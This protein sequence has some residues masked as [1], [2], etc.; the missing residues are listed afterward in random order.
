MRG[1]SG[2]AASLGRAC[3]PLDREGLLCCNNCGWYLWLFYMEVGS[4]TLTS[5]FYAPTKDKCSKILLQTGA[6]RGTIEG[7]LYKGVHL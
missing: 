2:A 3:L 7:V 6:V 5:G 4:Y 1:Q